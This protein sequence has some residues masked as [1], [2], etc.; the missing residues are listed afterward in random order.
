M[1][2]ETK[3][4]FMKNKYGLIKRKDKRKSKFSKHYEYFSK[5][6]KGEI[7]TQIWPNEAW[8]YHNAILSCCGV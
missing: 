7:A 8:L 2:S 1:E 5:S 3:G 6:N 4:E